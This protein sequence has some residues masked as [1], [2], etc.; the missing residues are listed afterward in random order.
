MEKAS[1]TSLVSY[2]RDR[3]I[4]LQTFHSRYIFLQAGVVRGAGSNTSDNNSDL[5]KLIRFGIDTNP[6]TI[7]GTRFLF[8]F[9]GATGRQKARDGDSIKIKAETH[10]DLTL[11]KAPLMNGVE[12]VRSRLAIE[13]TYLNGPFMFKPELFYDHYNFD[14]SV[15]ILGFYLIGSYFLTG[16]QRSMNNGLLSR[17]KIFNPINHGGWGAWEIATRYS[18]YA[19]NPDFYMDDTLY[20]GWKG[21]TREK[22]PQRGYS[23]STGLNWYPHRLIRLMLNNVLTYNQ[24]AQGNQYFLRENAWMFR[25][26]AEY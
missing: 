23:L 9:S 5:D 19:V 2:G 11:F 18:S 3:G 22:Y 7:H 1:I 15:H 20:L 16:E 26:Q 12:Y 14:Q 13:S 4:S 17:Q 21:L 10:S 8:G 6:R 25:M 24:R